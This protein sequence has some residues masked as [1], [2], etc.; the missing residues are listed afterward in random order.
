MKKILVL[1]A[2]RSSA[3]LIAYLLKAC[4]TNGWKL[5]VAD[6]EEKLINGKLK[7]HPSGIPLIFDINNDTQRK[8]EIGNHHLVIS[9]L[10]PHLHIIA[11]KECLDLS[12]PFMTASYVSPEI[13]A[14]DKDAKEKGLLILMESGLDPGIDHM[15]AMEE[16]DK[17]KA[18]G[19]SL[20]SFKSYTGGL[21][22]P[23]SDTNPWHYKI[24]WNP[25]N[26]VLAGQG[27]VKYLENGIYKYV[28]YHRLFSRIENVAVDDA[29]R[30]EGYLNRDSLKY[31]DL[32][33]LNGIDTFIRGTLRGEGY[34][35]AWDCLVQLGL[36][37]D[38]YTIDLPLDASFV[39][40]LDAY[41]PA[42]TG[43]ISE[44]TCKY[45]GIS[46]QSNEIK[47]MQWLG[48]FDSANKIKNLNSTPAQH[49]QSLL[50]EKWK[51]EVNDKDRIVMIHNFEYNIGNK[52]F[53]KTSSLVV[54]GDDQMNTAMAKTVGLPLGIAAKLLLE[55]K[56]KLTGVHVPISRELYY[57]ILREL[58]QEGIIFKMKN[59]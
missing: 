41:L 9:L 8:R 13:Q 47:L 53:S 52:L 32:Y 46:P 58:E 30:F 27:T 19:G 4:A 24:S 56:I 59:Q 45:L 49:L 54:N 42:G 10:P 43:S 12:V 7:S 21:V 50:E 14:L 2:G 23:E 26:V 17:I 48:L 29:G 18:E 35:K 36:T 40:L 28:P 31:I 15:S 44:R 25:R 39:N 5:T 16:I 20:T 51:L 55:G 1:G 22:A 11:A 38:S 37:D 57:P 33:G 6:A 34:C 3:A